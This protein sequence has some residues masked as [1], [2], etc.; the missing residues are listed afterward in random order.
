MLE[1]F[2]SGFRITALFLILVFIIVISI[3]ESQSFK[4]NILI[5]FLM[6]SAGY[7]LAYWDLVQSM[8]SIFQ[9]SF[10]FAVL[11]PLS[12]WLF[13]KALFDDDFNWNM[14]YWIL[15]I[16][17]SI[18]HYS[19][20]RLNEIFYSTDYR[21]LR[22]VPY[23]ISVILIGLVIFES[24]KNKK[25][26]LVDSRL[27]KRNIF[28]IFSSFLGLISIF[29]FFT[30]DPL[31]LPNEF[32]LIQYLFTC[33]FIIFFFSDQFEFRNLF[34]LNLSSEYR[35][36]KDRNALIQERI[37]ERLL[38]KFETEK[39]YVNEG[40]TI[41]K[42]SE[43]LDEKEYMLRRAINGELGYTNFNSFLNHYRIKEACR[44]IKENQ[45]KELTYQEIA[46]KMGYQS[47]VTFNRAFKKET[48]T[49]PSEYTNQK[50]GP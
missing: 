8:D 18:G 39:T 25:F 49:T 46:Y 17:I 28:F 16:V 35:D 19:L 10:F 15:I 2:V 6:A 3:N 43:L 38:I 14:K 37:I 47:I 40:L 32:L 36:Q 29:Y 50:K 34:V 26:D 45:L 42:L 24:I 48:G 30:D 31:R 1:L 44:L 11:F 7:L 20:Y 22:F 4:K 5:F 13:S 23:L 12:F 33:I 21:L 9:V 41:T 27:K